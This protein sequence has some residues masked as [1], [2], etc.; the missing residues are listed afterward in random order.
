M[1]IP[2]RQEDGRDLFEITVAGRADSRSNIKM[3]HSV[4]SVYK[5]YLGELNAAVDEYREAFL[6]PKRSETQPWKH[7]FRYQSIVDSH[8]LGMLGQCA[9]FFIVRYEIFSPPKASYSFTGA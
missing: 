3:I 2:G 8:K 6:P 9:K 5:T 7:G 1:D 4:R